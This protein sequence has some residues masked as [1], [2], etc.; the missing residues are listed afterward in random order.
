MSRRRVSHEDRY[1]PPVAHRL[2]CRGA[3]R[4]IRSFCASNNTGFGMWGHELQ[5][6]TTVFLGGTKQ[7]HAA[8]IVSVE[9]TV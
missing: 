6:A 8:T 7:Y 1:R 5:L 9:L 4:R 3:V 2:N